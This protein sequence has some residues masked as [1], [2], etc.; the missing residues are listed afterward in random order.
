MDELG[1]GVL[2]LEAGVHLQEEELLRVGVVEEL[3]RAGAP[4]VDRLGGP[5][6]GL[7]QG[8]DDVRGETRGRRLLDHLLVA[9]LHGAVALPEHEHLA[10]AV[11]DH[12]DLDVPSALDVRLDEDGAVAEGGR[13]LG[14]RGGDLGVQVLEPAH[15]PHAAA[16][17]AGGRLDQQGQV[18]LGRPV[19]RLQGRHAGLAHQPLGLDLGAHRL[20][21]LGRR[22]DPGEPGRLDGAGEVGVLGQEAVAGVDRVGASA[23]GGVEDQ[24]DAQVGVRRGAARQ[25][26]G[27]VGLRHEGQAGVGVGVH[28]HRL[29]A[30][31]AAGREDAAGDLATVGDEESVDRVAHVGVPSALFVEERSGGAENVVG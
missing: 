6:G 25:A 27:D 18:G 3:D 2:H 29:D 7:V 1:D 23:P 14:L 20:D 13:R 17:A 8:G 5:S 11:A 4:V 15:D 30:E 22:A 19:G 26:Y 24:V 16:T 12:L 10:P 21:R 9:A 31:P 28:R